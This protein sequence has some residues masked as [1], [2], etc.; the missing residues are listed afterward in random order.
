MGD[1][2]GVIRKDIN[3][4]VYIG[5]TIRTYKVRWQQHKQTEKNADS[6]LWSLIK[7]DYMPKYISRNRPIIQLTKGW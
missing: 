3:K 7:A 1:I 2:Y 4:I 5:Q 6:F